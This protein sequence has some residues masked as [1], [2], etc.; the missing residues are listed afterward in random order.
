MRKV[1]ARSLYR[2]FA[3]LNDSNLADQLSG[4]PEPWRQ[5]GQ[6]PP[7]LFGNVQGAAVH[8]LSKSKKNLTSFIKKLDGKPALRTDQYIEVN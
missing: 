1:G 7:C 4:T 6:L 3:N 2:H 5:R 8:F